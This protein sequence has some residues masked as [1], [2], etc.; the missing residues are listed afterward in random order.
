MGFFLCECDR[1]NLPQRPGIYRIHHR[2]NRKVAPICRTA[3]EDL[4]GIIYIGKSDNL[5][6]RIWTFRKVVFDDFVVTEGHVAA[7]RYV[8][9]RSLHRTFPPSSLW[10]EFEEVDDCKEAEKEALLKYIGEFGE[11]PPLNYSSACDS[12][13]PEMGNPVKFPLP[14]R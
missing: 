11:V 7:N 10:F 6:Q 13:A 4:R 2:P 3:G 12:L 14:R 8:R 9:I 1:N 5:R